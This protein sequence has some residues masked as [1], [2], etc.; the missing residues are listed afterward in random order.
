MK[1]HLESV[2][3]A[4][5]KSI[6]SAWKPCRG[7]NIASTA[8]AASSNKVPDVVR[9]ESGAAALTQLDRQPGFPEDLCNSVN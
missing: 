8:N 6:Q 7:H 5:V 1:A 9:F 2:S 3:G 4:A